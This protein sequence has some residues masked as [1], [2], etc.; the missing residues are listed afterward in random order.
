MMR[1]VE[2]T[3]D[4]AF[5]ILA[6][7]AILAA[8]GSPKVDCPSGFLVQ[9]PNCVCPAGQ[10]PEL[11]STG[12]P[13]CKAD[14][15]GGPDVVVTPDSTSGPETTPG[16]DSDTIGTDAT[17]VPDGG[18][19]APDGSPVDTIKPDVPKDTG[20]GTNAVGSVCADDL[21]CLAGLSCFTWPKG[22]CTLT[23]CNAPGQ[24][25]PGSAVCWS[26][27]ASTNVCTQ[28]CDDNPDCR[29]SDGYACKRMSADFGGVDARLCLPSGKVAA[30]L[31]C[32]KPLD[33]VGSAVCLTDMPGGY[34]ARVGCGT[35]DAC[36]PGTACVLRNGKPV[37]LKTCS[38][39]TECQITTKQ[40]RK[41][42]DKTDLGKKAVKVCLDSAKSGA[43]GAACI[44]D[45][46]CDS[47]VCTLYAKGTCQGDASPCLADTQCGAAAPCVL[48][49]AAEKGTCSAPCSGDQKCTTGLCVPSATDSTSGTCEP[50]C[51]G[52][53]DDASC[54]GVPG[55]KCLFGTPLPPPFGTAISAYGCA[56]R[57]GGSAGA[58]CGSASDCA[59][60]QCLQNPQATAGYCKGSCAN[61]KPCP[62]GTVC[63]DTGVS[64]C[65]RMCNDEF[66]CPDQMVCKASA[67]T[68]NKVCLPP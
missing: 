35:A 50:A 52:P 43:V 41:C 16:K 51:K 17:T 67:Q 42:V 26:Q 15:A 10:H 18:P 12:A 27:D 29:I 45:L 46:D 60:K 1:T 37:C 44:A 23:N 58:D 2:V 53:G 11:A 5:P 64:E 30:G 25:C 13:E 19:D 34:C 9:G 57:P 31:G 48:D 36:D 63:V 54:G 38:G 22:Y 66:D 20:G 55:L 62:F 40:A 8:C 21:D 33:C 7:L 68:S 14:D 47:K 59:S 28:A 49:S 39:D 24:T 32:T 3:V 6:V 4:K 65:L 56:S 61:K